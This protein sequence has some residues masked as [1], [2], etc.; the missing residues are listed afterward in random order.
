MKQ[1]KTADY[2]TSRVLEVAKYTL[3]EGATV[4]QTAE[5]FGVSKSTIHLDLTERLPKIDPLIS[6][7]VNDVLD[8]NKSERHIRG[9]I[10]T[11]KRY[12]PI[13]WHFKSYEGI[14]V[15]R[16]WFDNT[17]PT[18]SLEGRNLIYPVGKCR[19]V[20]ISKEIKGGG[21]LEKQLLNR[22]LYKEIK[23]YDRQQMEK[24]LRDLYSSG[25]KDGAEAGNKAD[26]K[27]EIVQ[28]LQPLDIKGIGEKTKEKILQAYMGRGRNN[29]S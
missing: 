2:I 20:V 5:A 17:E 24:F 27:I 19:T 4:R 15:Q 29:E 22:K 9:G 16:L 10:S 8:T 1:G 13:K 14:R 7:M 23:K 21:N 18:N 28:F 3:N 12:K 11:S 25:F 26:T 6:D